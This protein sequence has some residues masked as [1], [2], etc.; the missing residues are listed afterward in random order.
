[1]NPDSPI[2]EFLIVTEQPE[3]AATIQSEVVTGWSRVTVF[4]LWGPLFPAAVVFSLLLLVG[5]IYCALRIV[6]IRRIEYA[7]FHKHAH[8][9]EAEDVPRTRLRWNRVMEH[10]SSD[11]EHKWRLAILEADIMLNELL[12]VQG[13]KG[14]TMGEKMK[15]VN[16][17]D[18]NSIDDAWEAHKMRN[19]VAHEG[20]EITLTERDKNRIIGQYAR[21]FNEFGFI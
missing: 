11:D 17:A 2:E 4:E 5:I 18:F 13:Y 9:V 14:E 10:A 20:S 3:F 15:Q 12:D 1:M 8:T 6:Q 16:R 7:N 21:V 19:R